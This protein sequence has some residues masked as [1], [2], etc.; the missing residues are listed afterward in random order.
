M[1]L[2]QAEREAILD[3]AF[4]QTKEEFA[5][6]V[7]ARTTLTQDEVLR[8][9]KTGAEREALAKVLAEVTKATI[10]NASKAASVRKISGGVEALVK[11]V[12]LVL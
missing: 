10:S 2:T 12:D 6:E 5:G 11:I 3:A 8:L 4:N 9:A 1:S 7:S